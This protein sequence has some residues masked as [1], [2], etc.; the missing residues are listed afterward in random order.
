MARRTESIPVRDKCVPFGDDEAI[1]SAFETDGFV[2]VTGVLSG[3][4]VAAMIEELWTSPTLLGQPGLV[5]DNQDSWEGK[6]PQSD[7]GRNFLA[8]SNLFLDAT[9]W[10]LASNP[11]LLSLNRL[12]YGR[13]NLRIGLSRYGVMRPTGCHPEWKTDE[14]WLHWDQNPWSQPGFYKVQSFVCLTDSTEL[15][16]GFVCVPRFHRRFKQWGQDNPQGTV[17]SGGRPVDLTYG[18]GQPFPVPK[19]DPC[20]SETVRVL[21]PAGSMVFWDSRLPHQNFPNSDDSAMRVIYYTNMSVREERSAAEHQKLLEQKCAVMEALGQRGARFPHGLS[22]TGKLVH[23]LPE[24]F[25]SEEGCTLLPDDVDKSK[26][27]EA[28]KLVAEAGEAE[29]GGNTALAIR[30]HRKSM[31]LFPDIEDWHGAIYA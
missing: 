7:G 22:A 16:G 1:L 3:D 30:L 19:D 31:Q 28:I 2:V 13:E 17:W 9:P 20:Q 12:L 11:K 23:C 4:E 24:R 14:S 18:D 25:G 15:S 10:D 5:R 21:A 26:L 27:H 29:S 8:S 6:W